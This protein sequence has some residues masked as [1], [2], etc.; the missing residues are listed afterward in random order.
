M[1]SQAEKTKMPKLDSENFNGDWTL[2]YLFILPTLPNSKPVYLLCNECVSV[3]KEY[4]F[5]R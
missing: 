1:A 2:K 5:K 3:V 4:N